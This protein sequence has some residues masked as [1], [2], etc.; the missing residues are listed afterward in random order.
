MSTNFKTGIM[1]VWDGL[2]IDCRVVNI[3]IAD[4]KQF[5]FY[6]ARPYVGQQRQAIEINVPNEGTKFYIDNADGLGIQKISNGGHFRLAHRSLTPLPGAQITEVEPDAIVYPTP[7]LIS[8][9]QIQIEKDCF[10]L[11]GKEYADSMERYH[12]AIEN[13]KKGNN[14]I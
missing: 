1:P 2:P 6:W 8:S 5:K 7:E 14:F 11:Y 10:N 4:E 12:K 9:M 3:I 13:L